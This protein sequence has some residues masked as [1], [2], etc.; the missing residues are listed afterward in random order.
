[1]GGNCIVAV[2][3]A[4]AVARFL[5][6]D[7]VRQHTGQDRSRCDGRSGCH[8]DFNR[9]GASASRYDMGTVTSGSMQGIMRVMRPGTE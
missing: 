6:E 2:A 8:Q 9:A 5:G 3:V 7:V 1:M 4:V